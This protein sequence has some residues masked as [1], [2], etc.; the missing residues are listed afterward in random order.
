MSKKTKRNS[1][2][3]QRKQHK[4]I[5][6]PSISETFS[7]EFDKTNTRRRTLR[8]PGGA[9][10][11]PLLHHRLHFRR[12]SFRTQLQPEDML[13]NVSQNT[14]RDRKRIRAATACSPNATTRPVFREDTPDRAAWAPTAKT[15]AN[16]GRT[17]AFVRDIT[18]YRDV[19]ANQ[20]K[21]STK[22]CQAKCKQSEPRLGSA[23]CCT[24]NVGTFGVNGLFVLCG[25]LPGGWTNCHSFGC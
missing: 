21:L 5:C 7:L 8:A 2:S 20:T 22:C 12:G 13:V 11:V 23:F 3:N 25:N 10:V 15:T 4:N 16:K 17:T 19:A 6:L 14:Q 18:A 9:D 24:P 1:I